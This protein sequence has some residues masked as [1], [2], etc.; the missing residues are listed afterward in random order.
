[1]HF[2]AFILGTAPVYAAFLRFMGEHEEAKGF[3]YSLEVSGG[4]RKLIWEGVPRSIRDS[5]WRVRESQ[6][7]L[8]IPRQLALFFSGGEHKELKLRVMGRIW[9]D[10]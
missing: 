6:D 9:K 10:S 7:G 3:R 1:M 8:F 2:E 5:H 4:G